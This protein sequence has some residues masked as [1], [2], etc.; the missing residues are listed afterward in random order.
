MCVCV[1]VY[2]V[3][4]YVIIRI[5]FLVNRNNICLPGLCHSTDIMLIQRAWHMGNTPV[6]YYCYD[7]DL[8]LFLSFLLDRWG[9]CFTEINFLQKVHL[10]WQDSDLNQRVKSWFLEPFPFHLPPRHFDC[11]TFCFVSVSQSYA[12]LSSVPYACCV[13]FFFTFLSSRNLLVFFPST[14]DCF[15]PVHLLQGRGMGNEVRK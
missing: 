2:N 14:T 5:S 9:T 13:S 12:F 3:M 11:F 10:I 4:H 8:L 6:G 7:F 15:C 1:C